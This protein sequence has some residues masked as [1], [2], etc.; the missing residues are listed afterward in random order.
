MKGPVHRS[1]EPLVLNANAAH[2][3]GIKENQD[4][5]KFASVSPMRDGTLRRTDAVACALSR[6]AKAGESFFQSPGEL[7]AP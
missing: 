2:F 6:L 3:I 1:P 5:G 7:E 4:F